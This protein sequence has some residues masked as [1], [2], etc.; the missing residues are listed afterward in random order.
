MYVMLQHLVKAA[1]STKMIQ[2]ANTIY[3][4]LD[5]ANVVD[6]LG[7]RGAHKDGWIAV[8]YRYTFR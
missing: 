1:G 7:S 5:I 4:R 6:Y 8:Q 2:V 3:D